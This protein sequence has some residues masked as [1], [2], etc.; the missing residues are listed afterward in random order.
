[1]KVILLNPPMDF[2]A[3]LGKVKNIRKY[4]VMIPHGLGSIA[5]FLRSNNIGVKIVDAYAEDLSIG[6]IVD[7]VIDYSPDA[8]GVSVVTPV[9]QVVEEIAKRIKEVNE[10][11]PIVLGGTHPSILPDEILSNPNIDFAIRG[12][13]EYAF[14]NLLRCIDNQGDFSVIKGI[15]YRNN[16]RIIHNPMPA[17]INN[18]DL[19]PLPA[20]DLLPMHL[21][22]AP[23]QWSIA[24][25]SYQMIGSRGCPYSCGFC[26]VGLGKE[27]RYK[28]AQYI[29][30]EIEYLINNYGCKQ[31][32]FVDTTFPLNK[33][34]ADEVCSEII[35]RKINKKI[36]WFT[37]TRVDIVNQEMLNLMAEA[38][39]RLITFGVESGNQR[40]LDF[41]K[42][43]ITLEQVV[44]AVKMAHKAKIDITASYI[45][46]LPGETFESMLNTI[47]FSKKLNTL[48]AQFNI[49]VPYPGTDVFNYA[50]EHGLLRN[51][52]W[53]NYVS[54]TSMTNL[55]P[56]FIPQGLTKEELLYLQRKAYNNYYLR[57]NIII[58][59]LRKFI[60]NREFKKYFLLA[61]FLFDTFK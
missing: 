16:G 50:V 33:K 49:I 18:L 28:S 56:P 30:K 39:C 58:K 47:K 32:V 36:V 14:L 1:M 61:K 26:Y 13:G 5:S 38:G 55:D 42:K 21:Y 27:V 23:P 46:G 6:E 53:S 45:L 52:D 7:R 60:V 44:K 54:L 59:H 24:L 8:I 2:E 29:C 9:I 57:P 4:T 40:I 10:T 37:S 19:L 12:E 34:H 31:V 17:Y 41:I 3:A 20:Y 25:P 35:R 48:Y 15:S 43:K 51:K 22:T 11:I